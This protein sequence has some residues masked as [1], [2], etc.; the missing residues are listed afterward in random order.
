MKP[1]LILCLALVLGGART[2]CFGAVDAVQV[3]FEQMA[4]TYSHFSL[5]VVIQNRPLRLWTPMEETK[6]GTNLPAIWKPQNNP[7]AVEQLQLVKELRALSGNR[8]T[9]AALLKNSNPKVRTLALG[10]IFQREDG[11]D[12]PLIASLINDPAPTFSNLHESMSSMA[13][14]RP[15]PEVENPQS[16]GDVAQAMLAF[17]GV[18]HNGMPV[19]MSFGRM[20]RTGINT[21]NFAEYWKK[22]AGRECSASWLMVKMKRATRQT[23]PI[24]P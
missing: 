11:R 14:P 12:L 15:V 21:N 6:P 8:Q 22:Y 9:L 19:G 4:Q 1:K 7:L 3:R 20:D 10:A 2:N 24:Q 16:V 13:G 23:T 17:W 18:P 5:T